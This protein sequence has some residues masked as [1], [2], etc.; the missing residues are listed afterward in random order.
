MTDNSQPTPPEFYTCKRVKVIVN[1]AASLD[2]D[3][4]Q[5]MNKEFRE[6]E[7]EWDFAITKKEGDGTR[8]AKQAADEGFDVVAA[9]GGDGTVGEV[10]SGLSGTA[11]HLA[12]FPGGTA[13]VLSVELGIPNPITESIKL[14]CGSGVPKRMD[15]GIANNRAFVLRTNFGIAAEMIKNA[16]RETK[17]RLGSLA[18]ALSLLREL[19]QTPPVPYHL[20]LDGKEIE[21]E[22]VF[23]MVANSGSLGAVG[24]SAGREISVFD[25]LLD[26]I[27][28]PTVIGMAKLATTALG[29]TELEQHWQVKEVV[30][31]PQ[32]P[33][34]IE[35]DG[36]IIEPGPVRAYIVPEAVSVLIPE[37]TYTRSLTSEV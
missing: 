13:N 3:F 21:L 6:A 27:L 22:G 15:M 19:P 30:V 37:A 36:E 29:L 20:T 35:M 5:T 32:P 9:Y 2:N 18:Y 4:L 25:G 31:A 8:L 12:I 33:Q 34:S 26:V 23:V 14:V 7:I 24:M 10:A 16:D 1:P 17:N 28:I 11:A